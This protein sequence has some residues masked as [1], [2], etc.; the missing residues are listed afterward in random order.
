MPFA[1]VGFTL[2]TIQ[3]KEGFDIFTLIFVVLCMVFARSAAMAFNR[4]LDRDIDAKNPRTVIREIPSGVIKAN[5]AFWFVGANCLLFI[6][7]TWF[8]N[9]TCFLLS[10]VALMVIL[11]Y[12]YTKRFTALC[13]L[14]LG[15]G[16]ALAPVGAY[17]AVTGSFDIIPVLLGVSVLFW[18][19]GFDIIYALQDEDFDK[20]YEL[21]SIPL[22]LG[23]VR[24]MRL[25]E[26]FHFLSAISL[27]YSI[28]L[29]FSKFEISYLSILAVIV[30]LS[31]LIYQHLI[32]KP[33]DLSRVNVSF[34]TTNGVASVIF[35]SLFILDLLI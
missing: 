30:F 27:I 21:N 31:L 24:A 11:G 33:N 3:S 2:G 34:F 20:T 22:A 17:L 13:H 14:V 5:S 12:S 10:P 4:W 28:I 15:L 9:M 29:V 8:I 6:T 32:I 35:G 25:S 26:V 16:L 23:R 7:C 18:V 1:M 19:A